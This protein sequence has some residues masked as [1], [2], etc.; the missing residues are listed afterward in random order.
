[1][2]RRLKRNNSSF[3]RSRE[4]TTATRSKTWLLR[5]LFAPASRLSQPAFKQVAVVVSI[6]R[7]NDCNQAEAWLRHTS[8][9]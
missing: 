7:F 9:G 4:P 1:V 2:A 6:A 3:A 8:D 5:L